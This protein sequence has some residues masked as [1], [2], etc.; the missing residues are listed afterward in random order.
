MT[1]KAEKFRSTVGT[2]YFE[3]SRMLTPRKGKPNR[4]HY[5]HLYGPSDEVEL[6]EDP[7]DDRGDPDESVKAQIRRLSYGGEEQADPRYL[8]VRTHFSLDKIAEFEGKLYRSDAT[9][10]WLKRFIYELMVTRQLQ[11]S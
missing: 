9:L 6:G 3:D 8:E 4:G 11:N 5:G 10:Q 1:E 2:P 7:W